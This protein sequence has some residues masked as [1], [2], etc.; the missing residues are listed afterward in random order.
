MGNP[1]P[2]TGTV[3]FVI[4]IDRSMN[5][6]TYADTQAESTMHD[7]SEI[8]FTLHSVFRIES[9]DSMPNESGIYRVQLKLTSD[10]GQ[11]LRCLIDYFERQRE[12]TESWH[13]VGRLLIQVISLDKTIKLLN[14][15]LNQ[16]PNDEQKATYH[17]NIGS[18]YSN[19]GE[20][21]KAL[22]FHKRALKIFN[23]ALGDEH[24]YTKSVIESIELVKKNLLF[25]DYHLILSESI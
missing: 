12:G 14:D 2:D 9:M 23:S 19:M 7:D 8:L 3:L 22:S 4:P 10:N 25:V 17:F 1:D 16:M 18:V 11:Q 13:R 15:L 20:Y 21:P 6:M 5:T 24:P